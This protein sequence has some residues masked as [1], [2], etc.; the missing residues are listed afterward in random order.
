[1]KKDKYHCPNCLLMFD[2]QNHL[3]RILPE[4]NHTLCSYCLNLQLHENKNKI[5][6]PI[7]HK[8]YTDINEIST[9]FKENSILLEDLQ[10]SLNISF[11]HPNNTNYDISQN[12]DNFFNESLNGTLNN[13][14]LSV[15]SSSYCYYKKSKDLRC[16]L[17]ENSCTSCQKH[18]LPLN[19]I[20]ID[21]NEKLCSQCALNNEH[22]NHQ[23]ITE[24][25]FMNN[26]DNLIDLFQEV[27]NNQIK[28]LSMNNI[29]TEDALNKIGNSIEELITMIN[30]IKDDIINNINCQCQSIENYLKTRK[31]EIIEKYNGTNFDMATLRQS[32]LNWMQ[33]A[34]GKLD[35]LNSNQDVDFIK[36]LD[37]D[38][39]KNIFNLLHSGKQLNDRYKFVQETIKIIDKLETFQ[40]NGIII[41]PN[42][43]IIDS[44]SLKEENKNNNDIK[45][46]FDDSDIELNLN[47]NEI[48]EKNNL[49]KKNKNQ[50]N[51]IKS[52]LFEIKE[53]SDLINSLHLK[54][55]KFEY[56]C[57]KNLQNEKKCDSDSNKKSNEQNENEEVIDFVIKGVEKENENEK[58]LN[59]NEEIND[60]KSKL[61]DENFNKSA[62]LSKNK[63]N[64]NSIDDLS[65]NNDTL[66]ITSLNQNANTNE[67]L[68]NS[69]IY[70]KKMKQDLRPEFK[71]LKKKENSTT[72]ITITDPIITKKIKFN[73][74]K[75]N[76]EKKDD[77]IQINDEP[78][79][80]DYHSQKDI[81]FDFNKKI[82]KSQKE[83]R[84][85][86]GSNLVKTEKKKLIM[87]TS[88][89]NEANTITVSRS[90][91]RI[92]DGKLKIIDSI[93]KNNNNKSLKPEEKRNST[94][95]FNI[96]NNIDDNI[97]YNSCSNNISINNS[98]YEEKPKKELH[99]FINNQLKNTAPNFS[100]INLSGY[101]IQLICSYLH[102]NPNKTYK[103]MKFLGCN[104][105]DDDLFLLSRTLVDHNIQL[106]VLNLSSNKISD[107]SSPY[108]LD[109]IKD[110][111]TLKGISLYN[112][113]ISNTLKEKLKEYTKLG[114]PQGDMVQLYI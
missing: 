51:D 1:M 26:I 59:I 15:I 84:R 22:V 52:S 36:F 10:E 88:I 72:N 40:K 55:Y 95:N 76:K 39:N 114:R 23:I 108:I 43:N 3:P 97:N 21:E 74:L 41:K 103:E 111:D 47:I 19:V 17:A 37:N 30:K 38:P 8:E 87:K 56:I 14:N 12:E 66:L 110:L 16:G 71:N 6:C 29:N 54:K 44:I 82:P 61:T 62:T 67:L 96:E 77:E 60:N 70:H 46:D 81:F 80:R 113:L 69:G 24:N 50:E 64:E 94:N 91:N 90:P 109:L 85:N 105:N 27:D 68:L 32:T 48:S 45:K 7:D 58:N 73:N 18:S 99:E 34:T 83:V 9:H 28:Y 35:I 78:I 86:V 75:K 100:R 98:L 107:D 102:K 79:Y 33:N 106:L 93:E 20:C 65:F 104:I 42:Q 101:G 11:N 112:N 4:C 2:T 89:R 53:N 5:I 57:N 25:E 31:K 92:Y 63:G 49:N 13:L